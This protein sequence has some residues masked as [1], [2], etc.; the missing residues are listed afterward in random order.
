M[1][2]TGFPSAAATCI[3]PVSF[4][5]I[6]SPRRIHSI[7][8]GSETFPVKSRQRFGVRLRNGGACCLVLLA[9]HDG[10]SELGPRRGELAN[11][12]RKIFTGHRLFNQRA[13]GWMTIHR[14]EIVSPLAFYLGG[15]RRALRQPLEVPMDR[16]VQCLE[17]GKIP[18]RGV[19]VNESRRTAIS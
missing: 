12:F 9:A 14:A 4:E 7:I 10:E 13:P 19:R 6:N 8:S 16:H 15:N 2:T 5:I 1:A 11:H 17:H 18:I 3:G